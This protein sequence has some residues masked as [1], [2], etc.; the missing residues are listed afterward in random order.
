MVRPRSRGRWILVPVR[1]KQAL[2]LDT[3]ITCMAIHFERQRKTEK[4]RER[5][6]KTERQRGRET[7]RMC[8]APLGQRA[9]STTCYAPSGGSLY[10]VEIRVV[11]VADASLAAGSADEGSNPHP[12]TLRF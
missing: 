12:G 1:T 10:N 11:M 8:Y 3:V 4:A 6:R 9:P 2:M 7:E 5:Q